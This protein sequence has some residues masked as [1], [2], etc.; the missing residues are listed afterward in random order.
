MINVDWRIED[1]PFEFEK[2]ERMPEVW[3]F[4][5]DALAE[6]PGLDGMPLDAIVNYMYPENATNP[7]T[8]NMW[9]AWLQ[10][11]NDHYFFGSPESIRCHT[12]AHVEE[13][14]YSTGSVNITDTAEHEDHT[15]ARKAKSDKTK[16]AR[17]RV[18]Q[19][20]ML[21]NS[22][23][24]KAMADREISNIANKAELQRYEKGEEVVTQG[25]DGG[26]MCVVVA[27]ELDAIQRFG[28]WPFS[29][30]ES[31]FALHPGNTFAEEAVL[32]VPSRLTVR[33]LKPVE[34]ALIEVR[35]CEFLVNE[36]PD[37]LASINKLLNWQEDHKPIFDLLMQRKSLLLRNLKDHELKVSFSPLNLR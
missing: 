10:V 16:E 5:Q 29:I 26:N 3:K 19:I 34:I 24:L 21:R 22:P 23:L 11:K 6:N 31:Q 17:K 13:K 36:S 1:L 18:L 8:S 28:E 4:L 33:A 9:R 37:A 14:D 32:H 15:A 12:A 2:N 27:G 7:H 30:E 25:V 35:H 20:M